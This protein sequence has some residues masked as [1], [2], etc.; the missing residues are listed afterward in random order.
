MAGGVVRDLARS[1]ARP[2]IARAALAGCLSAALTGCGSLSRREAA[3]TA[4]ARQF[5]SAVAAGNAAVACGLLAP[6]TRRE[7]E[8]SADLPCDRALA[9]AD[10]PTHGH[11]V[12]TV[13]VYGDQA[14]VVFAGDTVFLASFSA[15]WR[16]TAAGCVYRG[17]QPYDCVISGR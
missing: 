15:G 6:Q 14:R 7:L 13:D 11:H 9:D 4:V 5:R 3:V 17:D 16:I 2:I 1:R 10:V 12:D 8:R